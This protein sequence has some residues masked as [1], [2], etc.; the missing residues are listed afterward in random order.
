MLRFL[1]LV[2]ET[3]YRDNPIQRFKAKLLGCCCDNPFHH[4]LREL[5]AWGC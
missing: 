5:N 4:V 3:A 2:I 1:H